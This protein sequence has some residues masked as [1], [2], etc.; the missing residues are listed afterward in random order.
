MTSLCIYVVDLHWLCFQ[1]TSWSVGKLALALAFV[2]KLVSRFPIKSLLSVNCYL[3]IAGRGLHL[4]WFT[5]KKEIKTK[6]YYR[7]K[8]VNKFWCMDGW[9]YCDC[10]KAQKH[11]SEVASFRTNSFNFFC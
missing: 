2:K 9:Y 4:M 5:P 6:Y 3:F 11:L 10:R 7:E 1:S 8:L